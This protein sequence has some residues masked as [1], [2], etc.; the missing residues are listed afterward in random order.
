M[1]ARPPFRKI[2][3]LLIVLIAMAALWQFELKDIFSLDTIHHY[4]ATLKQYIAL[5]PR[6]GKLIF[7]GIYILAICLCFPV[8]AL[9]DLVAGFLFGTWIGGGLV[10]CGALT[11][12]TLVFLIAQTGF[13]KPL[14]AKAGPFYTRIANEMHQGAAGYLLFM[15]L[16]PVFPFP[17]VNIIPA[18]LHV[19][20]W[21]FIW[22]TLIGI[23]P[24]TFV[25]ANLGETLGTINSLK[26]LF[27]PSLALALG[28]L[29]VLALGPITVKKLRARK[30]RC[31]LEGEND[32]KAGHAHKNPQDNTL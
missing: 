31:A 1:I 9:L 20:L 5:N 15:R 10:M 27:S 19:R 30:L 21:T 2:I 29:G 7:V 6:D 3:P 26:D 32:G 25:Y 11:G 12:A 22:T 4:G 28:L 14:R 13:G 18:L 16:V 23:A 8:A 24:M 17:L